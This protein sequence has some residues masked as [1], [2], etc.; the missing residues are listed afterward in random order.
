MPDTDIEA[1]LQKLKTEIAE[2]A[3]SVAAVGTNTADTYRKKAGTVA[4][5]SVDASHTVL[6]RI[7]TDFGH[8]EKDVLGQIRARPLQ[9][10]G[11]AVGV[12]VLIA[13]LSRR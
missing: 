11:L 4:S 5:Q 1:Q 10:L 3:K 9:A 6:D 8:I 12:G 7:R 13:I 2:L